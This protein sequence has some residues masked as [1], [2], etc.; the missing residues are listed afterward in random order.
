MFQYGCVR[1]PLPVSPVCFC[2]HLPTRW[3]IAVDRGLVRLPIY[4][5]HVD[6]LDVSSVVVL[7]SYI[8]STMNLSLHLYLFN[9][10]YN[11]ICSTV[12]TNDSSSP[13]ILCFHKPKS[14]KPLCA[15]STNCS[16]I[17]INLSL[18]NVKYQDSV[19]KLP[20][21]RQH[22]NSNSRRGG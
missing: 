19:Y 5:K 17:P 8:S 10:H 20:H 2:H 21:D 18:H 11:N 3:P 12:F 16:N 9:K 7:T 4:Y 1:V 14:N 6:F 15:Q 13:T 22:T